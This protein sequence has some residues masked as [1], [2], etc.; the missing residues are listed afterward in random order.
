MVVIRILHF[1][2]DAVYPFFATFHIRSMKHNIIC[3]LKT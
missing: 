2:A 1:R 3:G